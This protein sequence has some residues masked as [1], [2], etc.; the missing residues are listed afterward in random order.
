MYAILYIN[1][2]PRR[3]VQHSYER[4]I[5]YITDYSSRQQRNTARH[6]GN[7]IPNTTA[8][9]VQFAPH[10]EKDEILAIGLNTTD[11][12]RRWSCYLQ[13]STRAIPCL[14]GLG[15][16]GVGSTLCEMGG[17]GERGRMEEMR[18]G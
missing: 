18:I 12:Y 15:R 17:V 2:D 14:Q 4:F 11:Q 3:Y 6:A 8:G 13:L 7:T 9:A 10:A 1:K 5:L 16:R